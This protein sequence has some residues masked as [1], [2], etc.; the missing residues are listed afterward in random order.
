MSGAQEDPCP[1]FGWVR[2]LWKKHP[3]I[4]RNEEFLKRWFFLY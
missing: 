1:A 4:N 2:V 3:Q